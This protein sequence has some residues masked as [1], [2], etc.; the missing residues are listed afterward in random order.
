MSKNKKVKLKQRLIDFSYHTRTSNIEQIHDTAYA[1]AD[2]VFPA[3]E[4]EDWKPNFP[5]HKEIL[6][7][8]VFDEYRIHFMGL[9]GWAYRN[10]DK[11]PNMVRQQIYELARRT[12]LSGAKYIRTFLING[13]RKP[14][15]RYMMDALPWEM[16][17][18]G[19]AKV[20]DFDTPNLKWWGVK[21][22]MVGSC[23]DN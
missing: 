11:H 5:D 22:K 15:E 2:L 7:M 12:R 23:K 20:I 9:A 18:M 19:G 13:S 4:P 21:S 6:T 16:I 17:R 10:I 14:S 8:P 1:I 3:E